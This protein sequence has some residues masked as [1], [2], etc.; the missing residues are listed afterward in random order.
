MQ[1]VLHMQLNLSA[2]AIR[3]LYRGVVI[4][5][6]VDMHR[7]IARLRIPEPTIYIQSKVSVC[8]EF[9]GTQER[10]ITQYGVSRK[11]FFCLVSKHL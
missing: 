7:Q 2:P 11:V 1:A 6:R 5:L 3:K 10:M 9:I 4:L 8:L